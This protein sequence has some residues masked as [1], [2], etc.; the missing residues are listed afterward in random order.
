MTDPRPSE[1]TDD[2]P[3]FPEMKRRGW[4]DDLPTGSVEELRDWDSA[5]DPTVLPDPVAETADE[6][7]GDRAEAV[8]LIEESEAW[9][10]PR[11]VSN[12]TVQLAQ[13]HATLY[14]AEQQRIGNL[15]AWQVLTGESNRAQIREG[16][17]I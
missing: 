13:V 5:P 14:L 15:I 16:L 4:F 17:G 7:Y 9:A 2:R 8:R 6:A 12:V 1:N 11:N 3:V 10:D